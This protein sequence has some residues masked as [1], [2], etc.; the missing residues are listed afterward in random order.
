MLV[1]I[2]MLAICHFYNRFSILDPYDSIEGSPDGLVPQEHKIWPGWSKL[3]FE[4]FW[5][6]IPLM[7]CKISFRENWQKMA[8]FDYA[9][10][11][12]LK[13]KN[14]YHK[15]KKCLQYVI[16]ITDFQF[17]THMT[18][19][20]G[21]QMVWYPRNTR[22]DPA[23]TRVK[24]IEIFLSWG[25]DFEYTHPLKYA[26]IKKFKKWAKKTHPSHH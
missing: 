9:K 12:K 19:L 7:R 15:T 5:K 1:F 4:L 17:Q 6:H 10:S 23:H 26:G 18:P 3:I 11:K 21:P 13:T 16:F 2:I 8:N 25:Q 20:R 14:I 24:Q 22:S